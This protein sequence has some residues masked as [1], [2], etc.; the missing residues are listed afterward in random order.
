MRFGV[1]ATSIYGA[2]LEEEEAPPPAD[3]EER[4]WLLLPV[5]VMGIDMLRCKAGGV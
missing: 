3:W 4:W 2:V 5:G 1:A